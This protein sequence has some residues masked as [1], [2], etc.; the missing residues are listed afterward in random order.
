MK[1]WFDMKLALQCDFHYGIR[2]ICM[3]Y[4]FMLVI[5]VVRI[6]LGQVVDLGSDAVCVFV[7][8]QVL[9]EVERRQ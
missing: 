1:N 4:L 8:V 6:D 2:V 7:H 5:G 9:L 3:C